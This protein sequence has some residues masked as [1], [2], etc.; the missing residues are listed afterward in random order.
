M[1]TTIIILSVVAGLLGLFGA[2]QFGK[3]SER[4]SLSPES[5][6]F[7]EQIRSTP[8]PKRVEPDGF[9]LSA[10]VFYGANGTMLDATLVNATDKY[11]ES[12]TLTWVC[13]DSQNNQI[14]PL[15]SLVGYWKPGTRYRLNEKIPP[16]VHSVRL[17]RVEYYEQTSP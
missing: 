15:R 7:I 14:G 17:D 2:Y 3:N 5:Q 6:A 8:S 13:F 10:Q 9:V 1:K 12:A 11:I 16:K 4:N